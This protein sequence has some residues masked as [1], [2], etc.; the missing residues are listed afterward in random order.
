MDAHVRHILGLQA[1]SLIIYEVA[2]AVL[3]ACRRRRLPNDAA[4]A[5]FERV[6]GLN[7]A[8]FAADARVALA[9]ARRYGCTAYDASYLAL[10]QQHGLQLV[11]ADRRLYTAVAGE[12][13][14][15]IWIGEWEQHITL[16]PPGEDRADTLE[17]Q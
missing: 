5:I 7:I 13:P 1:P 2:N 4:D 6:I 9:L 10:A 12:L 14:W 3:M 11:T 8:C 17:T 16:E 15:V